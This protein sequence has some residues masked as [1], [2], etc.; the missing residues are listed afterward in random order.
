MKS[1]MAI[2]SKARIA[3]QLFCV[4]RQRMCARWLGPKMRASAVWV[5][6]AGTPCIAFCKG[7]Y[8]TDL[9]WLHDTSIAFLCWAASLA[10]PGAQP[11]IIIH[12]CVPGF[13][14]EM[15]EMTLNC[16]TPGTRVH[17]DPKC[18]L[19]WMSGK[20]LCFQTNA[21]LQTFTLEPAR[22]TFE[23]M[24][25]M[26]IKRRQM[27]LTRI[28]SSGRVS[29]WRWEV[30]MTSTQRRH[31]F[32]R[33]EQMQKL[34]QQEGRLN[35]AWICN[36]SQSQSFQPAPQF[37]DAC[38]FPAV[39]R[40]SRIFVEIMEDGRLSSSGPS[41]PL[42]PMETFAVQGLPVFLPRDHR[43]CGCAISG[44]CWRRQLGL[45]LLSLL[46]PLMSP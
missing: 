33:R 6:C 41:R 24:K 30:L 2:M 36:I 44:H 14:P 42:H 37:L 34:A 11:D 45:C 9:G 46:L 5:E 22:V 25:K 39:L 19:I 35:A 31:L 23:D 26:W 15:L 28:D 32:E 4:K 17:C 13:T 8:G 43:R 27:P 40:S 3:S 18:H 29:G 20:I 7:A 12:E 21:C 38:S 16:S 1:A 10:A